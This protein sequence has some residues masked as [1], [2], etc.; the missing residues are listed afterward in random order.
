MEFYSLLLSRS[1]R[2]L[3]KCTLHLIDNFLET[4]T[5]AL[6]FVHGNMQSKLRQRLTN[7]QL[8]AL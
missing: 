1:T 4:Y 7:I 3:V 2:D 5:D 6:Y 8:L